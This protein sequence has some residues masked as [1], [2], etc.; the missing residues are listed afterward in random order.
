[1]KYKIGDRIIV[2][3][4]MVGLAKLFSKRGIIT[5]THNI[6]KDVYYVSFVDI[7]PYVHTPSTYLYSHE[8]ELDK[9]Y[10]RE[11]KLDSIL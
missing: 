8:I 4:N 7:D 5:R 11:I 9:Q 1:M 10:Y 2:I 6:F 3:S